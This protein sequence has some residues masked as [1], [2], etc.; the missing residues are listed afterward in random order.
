MVA[1]DTVMLST[2]LLPTNDAGIYV[3]RKALVQGLF[4]LFRFFVR[5]L[6]RLHRFGA[7]GYFVVLRG[8]ANSGTLENVRNILASIGSL[9]RLLK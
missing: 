3:Q 1:G 7:A 9:G 8:M 6:A 2:C 4:F 5:V